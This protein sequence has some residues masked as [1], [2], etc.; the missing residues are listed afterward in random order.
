[1]SEIRSPSP[2]PTVAQLLIA[3]A[4]VFVKVAS[5]GGL[6]LV[7]ALVAAMAWR[8]SGASA[9]Y[10]ALW[11]VPIGIDFGGYGLQLPLLMWINDAAMALFFLVVGAEIKREL[12]VGELRGARRAMV[13]ALAALGGML[14]PAGVYLLL[15]GE[16][17]E[18]FGTPMATDIA[19][20]LAAIRVLG[21]RVPGFVVKVLMGLAIIDDLGA[22]IV[23][24]VFYGGDLHV[25]SLALGGCLTA[26]LIAMNIAGVW[27]T[28]PYL[29][30]GVPLWIALHHGG[31]HPTI[32]GVIVGLCIPARGVVVVDTIIDQ[33]RS[34]LGYAS[35][36]AIRNDGTEV[37]TVLSSLE[38]RL[39][40]H[41]APL[42]R[43]VEGFN[44]WIQWIILPLFALANGGVHLEG[45]GLGTLLAPVSI[46]I[47]AGLF[48]GKQ[49][50][51]FGVILGCVKSGLMPLPPGVRLAH[52]WGMS[53]LAG[54]GFTMSLFVAGLAFEDGSLLHNEA[55]AGILA[56]STLAVV[57]G[58]VVLRFI[59]PPLQPAVTVV[60]T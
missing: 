60:E 13:P 12:V 15:A 31:I 1:M 3:P 34:L 44:P 11:A 16:H 36:E 22:I 9:S 29:V 38:R 41:K 35:D 39:E 50:G 25:D 14:V 49:L 59:K 17:R 55:K 5:Q 45:M 18:G 6:L 7:L 33:A 57:V 21:N 28:T 37:S 53:I 30:I 26:L 10:M 48:V 40:Q 42:E 23:I 56:G 27:R 54:I 24:A 2:R 51:I 20:S 52:F 43:V 58:M 8:N 46:G 19:F 47:I 32:A 4:V